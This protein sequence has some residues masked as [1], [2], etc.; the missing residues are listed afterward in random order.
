MTWAEITRRVERG[1]LSSEEEGELWRMLYLDDLQVSKLLK[2]VNDSTTHPFVFP[3]FAF[4]A[5]TGAR[6]SEIC[7]SLIDD[8]DFEAG[9]VT[10][11]ERKR[12]KDL[13]ATTRKVP[14]NDNLRHVMEEWFSKHP[15]GQFSITLPLAMP[16]R[17]IRT[18]VG[19]MSRF[20]ATHHFNQTL[21]DSKWS[22]VRGFHALRHSFGAIC[23][24]AGIPMNVIAAWMGHSTEEMKEHYQHILPQDQ[25][26]WMKKL[27]L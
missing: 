3:M 9:I 21:A 10:I 18:K 1:G 23:T 14:L 12:R 16:G 5:Y 20:E 2:F 27:P 7:R 8:F 11:R 15:G 17:K 25:Q 6:R 26:D 19:N 22:N 24:R 13:A 4:A